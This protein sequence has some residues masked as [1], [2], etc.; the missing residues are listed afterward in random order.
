MGYMRDMDRRL[1]PPLAGALTGAMVGVFAGMVLYGDRLALPLLV[2]AASAAAGAL[3]GGLVH[4]ATRHREPKPTSQPTAHELERLERRLQ[5]HREMALL[6]RT[7]DA[8]ERDV[9]SH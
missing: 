4:L 7:A 2:V 6:E 3:L 8:H 5:A 9:V 1:H